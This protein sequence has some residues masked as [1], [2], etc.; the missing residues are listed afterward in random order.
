MV[1]DGLK[2]QKVPKMSTAVLECKIACNY[3]EPFAFKW[4]K[5]GE[6]I[7]LEANK[8][9]YEFA[10]EGDVYKLKIKNFDDNDDADYEIYLA[11]P[12]DFDFSSKARIELDYSLG[13][14]KIYFST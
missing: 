1:K 6:P 14:L 9:K 2:N 7:D 8:D 5:N 4:K 10:I 3:S 11:E 12:E 13:K